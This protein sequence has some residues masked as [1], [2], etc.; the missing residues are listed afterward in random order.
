[1]HSLDKLR[2]SGNKEVDGGAQDLYEEGVET[3]GHVRC[4]P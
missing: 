1:M 4:I 2:A 3:A